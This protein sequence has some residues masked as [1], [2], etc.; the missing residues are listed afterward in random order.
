MWQS[1]YSQP[2]DILERMAVD[3]GWLYRNRVVVQS[4]AQNP[5]DYVWSVA[6]S[7]VPEAAPAE[8]ANG[9]SEPAG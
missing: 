4:S 5:S 1:V 7:F 3:G 8:E 2:Y 6:L 9:S